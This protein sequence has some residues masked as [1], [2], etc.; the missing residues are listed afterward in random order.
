M[1]VVDHDQSVAM[2]SKQ[3]TRRPHAGG[4][5]SIIGRTLLQM[6]VTS[7]RGRKGQDAKRGRGGSERRPVS[8]TAAVL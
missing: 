2:H 1:N 8:S 4:T 5:I 7:L 3:R 6:P